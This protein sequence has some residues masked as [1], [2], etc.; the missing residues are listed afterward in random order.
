[1]KR[2]ILISVGAALAVSAATDA[3]G[4]GSVRGPYGGA[5][6][7]GPMVGAAVRGPAGGAAAVGPRGN[8]AYRPPAG[9]TYYRS[10]TNVYRAGAPITAVRL[11][12]ALLLRWAWQLAPP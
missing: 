1:M 12:Q 7:R 5:A 11:I 10:G 3:F 2:L 4:W 8:T 9:G 6:Y